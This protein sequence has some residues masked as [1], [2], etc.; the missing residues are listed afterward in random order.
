VIR[1]AEAPGLPFDRA[2]FELVVEPLGPGQFGPS[3]R[4]DAA[5]G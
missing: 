5:S 3:Q 1:V 4:P 2:E